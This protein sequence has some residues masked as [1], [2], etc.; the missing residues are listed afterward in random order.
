MLFIQFKIGSDRYALEAKCVVEVI[1][2]LGLKQIPQAPRGIAGLF[3]YRGEA[4]PALD[5]AAMTTGIPVAERLSTRIIV[6]RIDIP[7]LGPKLAGVIAERATSTM[8]R[9]PDDFVN[10]GITPGT[11][12]FLGP[13]LLDDEGVIQWIQEQKLLPEKLR[14]QL[15]A[16]SPQT[17][18]AQD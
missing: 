6:V 8:R 4:V 10:T 15:F 16:P 17:T 14:R 11:A 5:L 3:N 1:P 9:N 13:V 12:P 18:N 2:L 7:A